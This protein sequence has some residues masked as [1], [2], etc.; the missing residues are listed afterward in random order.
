[1]KSKTKILHIITSLSTGGAESALKQLVTHERND[2]R[3]YKVI[4]LASLGV[5]GK[6]MR[7]EGIEVT[8]LRINKLFPFPGLGIIALIKTIRDFKPDIVHTWMYHAN[9][10]GG[11]FAKIFSKAKIV[12]SLRQDITDRSWVKAETNM[13]I[14][15]SGKLA[16]KV[17][18]VIVSV[19]ARA[20]ESHVR[21]NYPRNKLIHIANG[22]DTEKYKPR[23]ENRKK[24]RKQLGVENR[25]TLIGYFARFHP[26]K[27]H[28]LFIQAA[29]MISA[30]NDNVR[31]LLAGKG[32]HD[33]NNTLV[34]IIHKA[35]LEKKI[36]LLGLRRD[37]NN[38]YPAL[39]IY[40]TS[41]LSEG[42][43]MAVAEAMA[44]GI[45]CAV[46]DVGDSALLVGETGIVVP[47]SDGNA[48]SKAWESLIGRDNFEIS[49]MSKNSRKRVV[50]NFALDK[51]IDKYWNLYD[52]LIDP[53]KM[54]Q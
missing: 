13:V 11:I 12:W 46:T 3:H 19:S 31:F 2:S 15:I 42:F 6:E 23:Q 33:K 54:D 47:S 8:A 9:F 50:N 36:H 4:G 22:I 18:D 43:P 49:S 17:P 44:S 24:Y 27:N 25:E 48:L 7:S 26:M 21:I 10:L 35:G 45:P 28:E 51:A 30:K 41:S 32:M 14:N 20:I 34:S 29:Q 53:G 5:I 16:N 38:W 39:D 52:S 37:L 40:S 1:M